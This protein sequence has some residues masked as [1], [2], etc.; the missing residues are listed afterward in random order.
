MCTRNNCSEVDYRQRLI[1]GIVWSRYAV[2]LI[3]MQYQNAIRLSQPSQVKW[4]HYD[5]INILII[6]DVVLPVRRVLVQAQLVLVKL[7]LTVLRE[8]VDM[9]KRKM[10]V[11]QKKS[12]IEKVIDIYGIMWLSRDLL[13]NRWLCT[14]VSST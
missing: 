8:T 6:Q 2:R 7:L 4:C 9:K 3:Q 13:G 11:F 10:E 12:S 5:I 1:N 14:W